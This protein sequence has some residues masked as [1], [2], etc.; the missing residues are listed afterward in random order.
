MAR[1]TIRVAIPHGRPDNFSKLL[2]KIKTEHA[3][4]AKDCPLKSDPDVDMVTFTSKLAAADK[5]RTLSENLRQQSEDAM[6]QA[7][8]IYGTAKG[9]N[10]NTPGTLLYDC[11]MIK[12]SLLKKYKGNEETLST[13]GFDV[14]I[15]QAK[16]PAPRVKK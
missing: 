11:D 13:Y 10:I 8:S 6:Q 2:N 7:R 4:L 16:S 14:I 5:L 3:R 12:K 9:Q 1:K 15:G